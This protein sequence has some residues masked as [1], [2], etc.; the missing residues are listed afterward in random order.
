MAF[1]CKA[2][3][4]VGFF[5]LKTKQKE[6]IDEP[7][8]SFTPL[9]LNVGNFFLLIKLDWIVLSPLALRWDKCAS[10]KVVGAQTDQTGCLITD[11]QGTLSV[12]ANPSVQ[13]STSCINRRHWTE[14]FCIQAEIKTLIL[15]VIRGKHCFT[16]SS[17]V[18]LYRCFSD[19]PM[20]F[21]V[22]PS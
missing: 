7:I 14:C 22:F 15:D 12:A 16:T 3:I 9:K 8:C 17:V 21:A 1:D 11:W 6:F 2:C 20:E 19:R 10:V 13:G 18:C 4:N 5:L